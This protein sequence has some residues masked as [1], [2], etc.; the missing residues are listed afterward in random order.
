MWK[1]FTSGDK[2]FLSDI[3]KTF[4]SELV[5]IWACGSFTRKTFE[6]YY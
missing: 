3:Y 5:E 1:M 2:L 4:T 6:W